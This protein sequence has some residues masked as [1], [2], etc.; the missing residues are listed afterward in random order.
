MYKRVLGLGSRV[1]DLGLRVSKGGLNR[2]LGAGIGCFLLA[3]R[4]EGLRFRV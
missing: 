3:G 4:R 1:S 2:V